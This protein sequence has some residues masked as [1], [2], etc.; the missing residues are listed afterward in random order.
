MFSKRA[1]RYKERELYEEESETIG[2]FL[3]GFEIN[4]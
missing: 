3:N 1:S 4:N 2:Y